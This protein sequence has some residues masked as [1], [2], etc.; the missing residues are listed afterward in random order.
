MSRRP[1]TATTYLRAMF[2]KAPCDDT[3]SLTGTP[4]RVCAAL[5]TACCRAPGARLA[6]DRLDGGA[7]RFGVELPRVV[8]RETRSHLANVPL[9]SGLGTQPFG[10][11]RASA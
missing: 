10:H 7:E 2:M 5:H 8:E 11:V 1:A 6:G 9:V 4:R 3:L